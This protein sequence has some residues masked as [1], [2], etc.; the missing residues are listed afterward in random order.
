MTNEDFIDTEIL[1][2]CDTGQC[3]ELVS[4]LSWNKTIGNVLT[5]ENLLQ[6]LNDPTNQTY[7]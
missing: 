4:E 1:I 5:V 3:R 7:Y 6:N 2:R